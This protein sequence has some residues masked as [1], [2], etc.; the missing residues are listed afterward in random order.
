MKLV[1]YDVMLEVLTPLHIGTG[2]ELYP[3]ADFV[4]EPQGGQRWVRLIDVEAA[5]LT[6]TPEE[7]AGIRDGRIAAGM[8]QRQREAHTR[9]LLPV[10]GPGAVTRTRA[11]QRLPD[12]R[13]FIPGTT[14][15]GSIRTALLQALADHDALARLSLPNTRE[16]T[17][18]QPIEEGAFSVPLAAD[19]ERVEFPNRDLNRAIRVS[20][21]L[22]QSDVSVAVVNMSAYRL[23]GAT[24]RGAPSRI[25]IWCEAIEPGATFK[26]VLTLELDSPVWRAMSQTQRDAVEGLFTTWFR[27]A[28]RLLEAERQAWLD[29]PR[30]V[31]DSVLAFLDKRLQAKEGCANLGWGGGWRSKTLGLRIPPGRLPFIAQQYNLR[32][33]QGRDFPQRFPV[34]RKLAHAPGGPV[35]PGWVRVLPCRL[36]ERP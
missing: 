4:E 12:G 25:P 15:K 30:D 32:R 21:F 14:V 10:R 18:A 26:G 3:D 36:E 5:L 29:G 1:R 24:G 35:P 7:I 22:P 2:Q 28:E 23:D 17:G 9:A 16:K 27:S 13:P 20:D 33:W 19:R 6:M 8:G 11:L 31:R 34:T